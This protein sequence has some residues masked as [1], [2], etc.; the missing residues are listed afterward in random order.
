MLNDEL[1]STIL[2]RGGRH[3]FKVQRGGGE[4]KLKP[5]TDTPELR[6]KDSIAWSL[7]NDRNVR[8]DIKCQTYLKPQARADLNDDGNFKNVSQSIKD[9]LLKI[10]CRDHFIA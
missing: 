9:F 6:F 8:T 5:E 10:A 1:N 4:A 7:R 3:F 2:E